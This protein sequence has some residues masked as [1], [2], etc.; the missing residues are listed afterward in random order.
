[1]AMFHRGAPQ[2]G[3]KTYGVTRDGRVA[4]V[5][6]ATVVDET[7]GC[8]EAEGTAL[9][10]VEDA[11][12]TSQKRV[13]C[14]HQETKRIHEGVAYQLSFRVKPSLPDPLFP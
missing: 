4:V 12:E 2:S 7:I 8:A 10:I 1:M 14:N 5:E 6:T 11:M 13:C 3:G 9:E